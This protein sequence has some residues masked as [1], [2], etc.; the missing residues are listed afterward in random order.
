MVHVVFAVAVVVIMATAVTSWRRLGLWLRDF[1]VAVLAVCGCGVVVAVVAVTA[2]V[3]ALRHG[4]F[5]LYRSL[6]SSSSL[7]LHHFCGRCRG[8]RCKTFGILMLVLVLAMN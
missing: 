3:I 7:P 2:S 6:F 8:H 4:R 5:V 1:D